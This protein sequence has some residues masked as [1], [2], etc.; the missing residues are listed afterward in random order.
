MLGGKRMAF[1]KWF[2]PLIA[3]G[4]VVLAQGGCSSGTTVTP[5]DG[6]GDAAIHKMIDAAAEDAG[7]AFDMTTGKA[8]AANSDCIGVGGPGFNECSS[9]I[10][11]MVAGQ[12]VSL[13]PTPICLRPPPAQGDTF[14]N[15]DPAPTGAPAGY[16]HFCDGPDDPSSPGM[17]LAI[18]SV[19]QPN[20][21]ICLPKC[22]FGTGP[23]AQVG[24][25]GADACVNSIYLQDPNT[26][27][28]TGYGFCEGVCQTD[29]DCQPLASAL[30]TSFVCQTDVGYC[31]Q[32]KMTRAKPVGATCN[33]SADGT[34][35]DLNSGK[36][37]C[38]YD[39]ASLTG[40]GF[41]TTACV[42][43]GVACPAGYACD[44]DFTSPLDF[45]G[46][47]PVPLT[48]Q[49]LGMAG[50][51][52]PTCTSPGDGGVVEAG[53]P[54]T[55]ATDASVADGGDAGVEPASDAGVAGGQCPSTANCQA[56]TF[57]GPGCFPN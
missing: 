9:N 30:G 38:S 46:A 24:C 15:C 40:P 33:V 17:C 21:G 47:T 5:N 28:V 8:C 20:R 31:A 34:T 36:C 29:A 44:A 10:A 42:T 37:N 52:R 25:P 11:Y 50:I 2:W 14:G 56:L 57:I 16:P 22:T 4:V 7:A 1:R 26:L 27:A 13:W 54:P 43:G 35:D 48:G 32:T 6:G 18:D 19:P 53:T 49:P 12:T 3:C 51:C 23:S 45:G 39:S 55:T 41:C